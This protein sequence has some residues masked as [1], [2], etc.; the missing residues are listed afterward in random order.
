MRVCSKC[1]SPDNGTGVCVNCKS[2]VFKT[3]GNPCTNVSNGVHNYS[4]MPNQASNGQIVYQQPPQIIHHYNV[5]SAPQIPN[6]GIAGAAAAG[7]AA[8][9]RNAVKVIVPI[10]IAV[11]VALTAIIVPV[12][13]SNASTPEKTLE[14]FETAYNNLDYNSMMECF[15]STIRKAYDAGDDLLGG[16]LG[17]SYQSAADMLPFL[18]EV[19]GIDDEMPQLHIEVINKREVSNTSCMLD[20]MMSVTEYGETYTE[21]FTIEMVKEDGDWYISSD[22]LLDEF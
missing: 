14:K 6:A 10:I 4:G 2:T 17:F 3:I 21:D 20:V 11:I 22:V 1:G 15:D 12:V 16:L 8:G 18:S 7:A 9:S 5:S 13:V 19:M